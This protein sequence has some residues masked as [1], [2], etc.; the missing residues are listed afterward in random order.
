MNSVSGK[1]CLVTGSSDPKSIGYACAKALVDAGAASV[2]VSGRTKVEDAAASLPNCD[3]HHG[4]VSDL[5]KPETMKDLVEAAVAKMGG[6]D[7]LVISGCNGG[8]EYLG[9]DVNDVTSYRKLQD[10]AVHSPLML[11]KAAF[12]HLKQS[13]AGTVVMVTSMASEVPWPDTAPYNLAKAA[14]NC[15]VQTLAFEY[16]DDSVRVNA[17]LPACIHTGY[18]DIMAEKKRKRVREYAQLRAEAHP[19]QRNG[20][21]EEVAQAV[22]YLASPASSFTTGELLK[23]DG[24]LHL[25]NWFNKPKI[26]AEYVGGNLNG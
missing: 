12:P 1:R 2:T 9:L 16:R 13:G 23:V 7:I 19:L 18:L 10:V 20:A 25:S 17:V 22:L 3:R 24:G 21:P 8:S 11:A 14:Q 4:I 26:L 6:L 15:L 5:Y